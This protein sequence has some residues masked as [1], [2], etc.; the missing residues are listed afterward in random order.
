MAQGA[1]LPLLLGAER[2][3]ARGRVGRD[4][5]VVDRN[6]GDGGAGT[7]LVERSSNASIEVLRGREVQAAAWGEGSGRNDLARHLVG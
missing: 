7:L 4:G 6:T 3:G 5:V 1:T 2:D